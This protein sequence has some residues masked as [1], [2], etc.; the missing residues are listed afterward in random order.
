[1][2]RKRKKKKNKIILFAVEIFVLAVLLVGLF[3]YTLALRG[4]HD[5]AMGG[6]DMTA[7]TAIVS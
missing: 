6:G 1:M 3:V 4:L 5:A 2:S 7:E